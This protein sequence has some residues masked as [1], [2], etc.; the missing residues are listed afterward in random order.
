M[1][2]GRPPSGGL[3]LPPLQ[4]PRPAAPPLDRARTAFKQHGPGGDFAGPPKFGRRKPAPGRALM[5]ALQKDGP[6]AAFQYRSA[7]DAPVSAAASA[8]T[9]LLAGEYDRKMDAIKKEFEVKKYFMSEDLLAEV[10][11]YMRAD[12]R[13]T[14]EEAGKAKWEELSWFNEQINRPPH[15]QVPLGGS[16]FALY[17]RWYK[18]EPRVLCTQPRFLTV[19]H[20]VY[21]FETASIDRVCDSSMLRHLSRLFNAFDV[22]ASATGEASGKIDWRAMV[23]GLRLCQSQITGLRN[24]LDWGFALYTS[25]GALHVPTACRTGLL[26]RAAFVHLCSVAGGTMSA[27]RYLRAQA[28]EALA[29][30]G[31]TD[32]NKAPHL[33]GQGLLNYDDFERALQQRPLA[34]LLEPSARYRFLVRWEELYH[35]ALR[36]F[37]DD[38]RRARLNTEK[39]RLFAEMLRKRRQWEA[40]ERAF[41]RFVRRRRARQLVIAFVERY[42]TRNE[43]EGFERWLRV[44]M[45]DVAVITIQRLCRGYLSRTYV[46]W[47]HVYHSSAE[48]VQ[49]AYRGHMCKRRLRLEKARRHR[50]CGLIQRYWRGR[51]GRIVARNRLLERFKREHDATLRKRWEWEHKLEQ[52]AARH[53]QRYI[54]GHLG[55]LRAWVRAEERA[56]AE[57]VRKEMGD[58]CRAWAVRLEKHVYGME[59]LWE[60]ARVAE[61]ERRRAAEQT[62]KDK[63]KILRN[64]RRRKWEAWREKTLAAEA[65]AEAEEEKRAEI[66]RRKWKREMDAR[67]R[68]ELR[69][70]ERV[71]LAPERGSGEKEERTAIRARVKKKAKE[72]MEKEEEEGMPCEYVEAELKALALVKEE[73]V[74]AAQE[75][76][77]KEWD[78]EEEQYQQ[79]KQQEEELRALAE[80]E[81]NMLD[82]QHCARLLQNAWRGYAARQRALAVI[83][84]RYEKHYDRLRRTAY[85]VDTQD[86]SVS[87]RKHFLLGTLDLEFVPKWH[88]LDD[89]DFDERLRHCFY[90][91]HS[92]RLTWDEPPRDDGVPWSD[93][94]EAFV[95]GEGLLR[96]KLELHVHRH[97]QG[98][99]G[100]ELIAQLFYRAD[101]DH[102]GYLERAELRDLFDSLLAEAYSDEGRQPKKPCHHMSDRQLDAAIAR[103][104]NDGDGRCG[105]EELIE[106]EKKPHDEVDRDDLAFLLGLPID[107]RYDPAKEKAR[108]EAEVMALFGIGVKEDGAEGGDGHGAGAGAGDGGEGGGEGGLPEGWELVDDGSGQRYYYNSSTGESS[109]EPPALP[110]P[111]SAPAPTAAPALAVAESAR[112]AGWELVD[113]GSGQRYYYNSS[114]GE[115]SWEP[116]AQ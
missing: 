2:P 67:G 8:K 108:V 9:W 43:D 33:Q 85:Y 61:L 28:E 17:E 39:A 113:D 89:R 27:T 114:T 50:A 109:W 52:N 68:H 48:V 56:R 86:A 46:W 24:A 25:E 90:E 60:A 78:A 112:A 87:W 82:R 104:D 4:E 105:L 54:R 23:F 91:A 22:A 98:M 99:R 95:F 29:E 45:A 100:D 40:F 101:T 83:R 10:Y 47:L 37:I 58:E 38:A 62:R 107:E 97:G 92:M 81:E 66:W 63:L 70:V 21:G 13:L 1:I 16:P 116:P 106:W 30:I 71:L 11:E 74:E 7:A 44:T 55:R 93:E 115:S 76:V 110:L 69:R 32:Y 42:V 35:P 77:Q 26:P 14:A 51:G 59:V 102:S 103:L 84:G 41:D 88:L 79:Q 31:D 80:E 75:E 6:A 18:A 36:D 94:A 73:L 5:P 65:A 3:P 19:I 34:R 15:D 49:A 20:C 96:Q 64:Q 111:S 53:L 57:E 12:G 72:V